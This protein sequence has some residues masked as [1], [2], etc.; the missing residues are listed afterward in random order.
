MKLARYG[1]IN[2][3][4]L[5][6]FILS[7]VYSFLLPILSLWTV[8]STKLGKKLHIFWKYQNVNISLLRV[9][10]GIRF[11]FKGSGTVKSRFPAFYSPQNRPVSPQKPPI[12]EQNCQFFNTANHPSLLI[13]VPYSLKRCPFLVSNQQIT[14]SNR[15]ICDM[16][17]ILT[18]KYIRAMIIWLYIC[19]ANKEREDWLWNRFI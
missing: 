10:H 11:Y 14:L 5:N 7:A 8:C 15:K 19:N 17:S 12:F 1:I 9:F 16:R 2:T 13:F 6:D 4:T 18:V 3:S